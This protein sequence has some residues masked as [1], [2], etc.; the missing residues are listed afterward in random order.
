[1]KIQRANET[2]F[3]GE[4]S[5]GTMKR[6]LSELVEYLTCEMDFPQG[7]FLMTGTGLVPDNEFTLQPADV[8]SI[9]VGELMIENPVES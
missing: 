2:V 9:R 4:T 5:T 1:M 8:V 3:S 6:T 7:V